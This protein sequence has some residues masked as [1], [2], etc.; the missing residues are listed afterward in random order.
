[1]EP[2]RTSRNGFP[3]T[4]HS[5]SR[6]RTVPPAP[7][8]ITRRASPV[9]HDQQGPGGR[10]TETLRENPEVHPHHNHHYWAQSPSP[11][12][13]QEIPCR[14][15]AIGKEAAASVTDHTTQGG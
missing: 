5:P 7:R 3:I 13:S 1:M 11:S 14:R 15:K 2:G 9:Q 4:A 6:W 12:G 8:N 10:T